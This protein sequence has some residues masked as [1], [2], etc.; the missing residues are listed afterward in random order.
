M[1]HTSDLVAEGTLI[2]EHSYP[3]RSAKYE[4][5]SLEGI[6]VDYYD[7]KEKVIHEVKK[8]MKMEEA[9]EWQLKY[10][11]YVFEK[12]GIEG[13]SGLLAYPVLR[14]TK[15]VELT[16]ADREALVAMESDIMRIVQMD[17][18]PSKQKK[19]ICKRCSYFDFCYSAEMGV[20]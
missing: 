13:C 10:Y 20:E 17:E 6:R 9:D 11:I 5:I 7:P 3:Q 4:E 12:H 2:H 16:D 18:C 14:K 1:E 15:L 19:T 8:S